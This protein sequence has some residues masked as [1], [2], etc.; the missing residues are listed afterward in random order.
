MVIV[1]K[2][3]V[4]TFLR[5]VLARFTQII[6]LVRK[7]APNFGLGPFKMNQSHFKLECILLC[8]NRFKKLD[9][10]RLLPIFVQAQS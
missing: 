2:R 10:H 6:W 8:K 4:N 7:T 1:N 3:H 5:T 9:L